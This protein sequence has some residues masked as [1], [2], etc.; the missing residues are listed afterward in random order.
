MLHLER[1]DGEGG[2]AQL[3]LVADE[4]GSK[5]FDEQLLMEGKGCGQRGVVVMGIRMLREQYHIV[6]GTALST[7]ECRS[8][9]WTMPEGEQGTRPI[10]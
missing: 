4:T 10:L 6:P 3:G 5:S 1:A 9:A 7:D 2:D 8:T